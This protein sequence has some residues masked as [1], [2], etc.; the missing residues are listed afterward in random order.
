[1]L[2]MGIAFALFSIMNVAWSWVFAIC[3]SALFAYKDFTSYNLIFD[4]VLQICYVLL[5]I[6]GLLRWT[7][8]GKQKILPIIRISFLAHC[9]ALILGLIV[10]FI[11]VFIAKFFFN[12]AFPILDCLTTVFSFWAMW[13]LINRV[14]ETWIYWLLI[15]L[16]YVGIHSSRGGD[17]PVIIYSI[18]AVLA[19]GGW[20]YWTKKRR[21][22]LIV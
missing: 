14:N 9:N 2:L 18:Y 16:V 22:Q 7:F 15:N 1:M 13:L 20:I 4:G 6:F 5:S 21:S 8:Q 17:I 11:M 10:A 3:S 12:P 19:V